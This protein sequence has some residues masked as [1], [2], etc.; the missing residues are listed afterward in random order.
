MEYRN[1]KTGVVVSVSSELKGNWEPIKSAPEPKKE[2]ETIKK[3]IIK[4]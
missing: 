1:T 4:K 3:R 2:K